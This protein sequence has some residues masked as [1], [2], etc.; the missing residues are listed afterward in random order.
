[1]VDVGHEAK[2]QM[3]VRVIKDQA[4]FLAFCRS[5]SATDNLHEQNLGLSWSRED[6]AAHVPIN[7]SRQ[8]SDV[9]HHANIPVVK[10]PLISLR[11]LIGVY[12]SM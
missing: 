7:A 2:P 11:S 4:V 1:M 8:A 6:D 9:A 12:A 3:R 5:Q 10:L